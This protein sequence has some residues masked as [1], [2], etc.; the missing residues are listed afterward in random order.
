ML[1]KLGLIGKT[2]T[3][4]FSK[5]FFEQLFESEKIDGSYDLL[6]FETE[7]DLTTFLNSSH[8]YQGFNVTIPYKEIAAK[9][10]K[11]LDAVAQKT[12][13]VNVIKMKGNELFGFNTDAIAFQQTLKP[14]LKS[15]HYR[16]LILGNGA[17]SKTVEHVLQTIGID[18]LKVARN[19]QEDQLSFENANEYVLQ[20]HHLIVNTTPIGTFPHINEKPVFPYSFLTNQHLVYDLVYN[21][22]PSAF[23]IEA[24]KHGAVIKDGFDMLQIQA[25]EAWKI[26]SA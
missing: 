24:K 5:S 11:Q 7:N 25:K 21:P 16:A 17:S 2:L 3:H 19:P 1:I 8:A 9:L 13:V 18:C 23:L 14:L 22:A 26:W 12:G 20:H 15:N 10:C 4:S 6:T